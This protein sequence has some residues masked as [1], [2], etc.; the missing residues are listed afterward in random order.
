MEALLSCIAVAALAVR[1][2]T[3]RRMAWAC[4]ARRAPAARLL[5]VAALL[6]AAACVAAKPRVRVGNDLDGVSDS[7]E[8]DA[9]RVWGK[10]R[11]PK[12]IEGKRGSCFAR[13]PGSR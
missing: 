8:D 4:V 11:E 1:R 2:E 5:L 12:K 13:V 3:R 10:R 7:E 6:C 9:W